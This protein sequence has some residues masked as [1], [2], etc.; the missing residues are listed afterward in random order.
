M[1]I[2]CPTHLLL[3]QLTTL[4]GVGEEHDGVPRYSCFCTLLFPASYLL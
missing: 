2:A 3:L 4:I 1:F